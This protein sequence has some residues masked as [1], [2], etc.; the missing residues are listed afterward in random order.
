MN[1]YILFSKEH[2]G[3]SDIL[4]LIFLNICSNQSFRISSVLAKY[5]YKVQY[6]HGR[7]ASPNKSGS[8]IA[9]VKI[10]DRR[11][12]SETVLENLGHVVIMSSWKMMAVVSLQ[13]S[14]VGAVFIQSV[15]ILDVS[16]VK[17]KRNGARITC[18]VGCLLIIDKK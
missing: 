2:A 15:H 9:F 7:L 17:K 18:S 16:K 11:W 10:W 5:S 13:A 4:P 1:E 3:P 12:K 8:Q 14:V 6:W